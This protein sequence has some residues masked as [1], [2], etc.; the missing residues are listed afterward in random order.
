MTR[1]PVR[2]LRSADR[3]GLHR[4]ALRAGVVSWAATTLLVALAL[5]PIVAT[6]E[7]FGHVHPKGT[8]PHM[9]AIATV[10]LGL[11]ARPAPAPTGPVPSPVALAPLAPGLHATDARPYAIRVRGPPALA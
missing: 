4:R 7:D 8:P 5:S 1:E 10:F 6:H 2:P 3:R 9:H 11:Q